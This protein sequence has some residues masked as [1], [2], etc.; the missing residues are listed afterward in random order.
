[1]GAREVGGARARAKN[2]KEGRTHERDG[3]AFKNSC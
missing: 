1:V 3:T 2:G